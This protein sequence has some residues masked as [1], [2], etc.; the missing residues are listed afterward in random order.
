MQLQVSAACSLPPNEFRKKGAVTRAGNVCGTG[1]QEK[2]EKFKKA[3]IFTGRP[4][5]KQYFA[6]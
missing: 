2:S 4:R 5:H 3:F 6:F 1:G